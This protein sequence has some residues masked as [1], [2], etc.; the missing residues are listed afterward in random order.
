MRPSCTY[1]RG[2][3]VFRFSRIRAVTA[4]TA[5][6]YPMYARSLSASG[7]YSR[8]TYTFGSSAQP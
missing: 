4:G 5:F 2:I 1:V 3:G 7:A 8:V 6:A